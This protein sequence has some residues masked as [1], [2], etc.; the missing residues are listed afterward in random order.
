ML[1][2][3]KLAHA[4]FILV[5]LLF[6]NRYIT[7][8]LLRHL[9]TANRRLD[10]SYEPTVTVVVPCYNEG[11]TIHDTLRSLASLE[12]PRE[13]FSIVVM[14]DASDAVTV[15]WLR[16]AE[17]DFDCVTVVYQAKN[18][19]KRL[20][21]AEAVR[22]ATSEIILSVDSDCLLEPDA[23]RKLLRHFTNPSV[24]AVGGVVRAMNADDN[25]L[26]RMQAVKYW[27]GYEYL[28]N[29]E[30]AFDQ[31]MCLSGCLTA[32][33]RHVLIELE[34]V[35]MARNFLGMPIKYGEDR[36]LTRKIVEAGYSTRMARDAICRTKV[37]T[38]LSGWIS[39]QLR[40]RRSNV[41]DFLGGIFNLHRLK[42][43]VMVHYFTLG[44][45]LFVYPF[46]IAHSVL[47]GHFLAPIVI[48]VG[49][50]AIFCLLYEK[51]KWEDPS[52]PRIS[53]IWFLPM[54]AMFAV[55]YLC[56]SPLAMLTL[57][58]VNWETRKAAP[59]PKPSLGGEQRARAA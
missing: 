15:D 32:Y 10:E 17:V 37:P 8:S 26:S 19:G 51:A 6:L 3:E 39:Q 1:F 57:A 20:N 45:L 34:P 46:A 9:K 4:S 44:L 21:I 5:A 27:V 36:F 25:W 54:P 38:S 52:V 29:L 7:G 13:K 53:A 58:T 35:L 22:E 49:V 42:P 48:H 11:K 30:D 24:V 47:S 56:L 40:W 59:V 55:S 43:P 2:V 14:D 33:R 12:Y 41:V 31:V 23:L 16:R 18:Q 50:T 28:K